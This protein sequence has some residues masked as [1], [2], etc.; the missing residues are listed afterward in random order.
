MW[1]VWGSRNDRKHGKSP[2]PL[3]PAI[4]WALDA[5]FHLMNVV[6]RGNQRC[7]TKLEG[8]WKKPPSGY[9]KINT[10]G[11]FEAE[12]MSGATG[13]VIRDGNGVFIKAMARKLPSIASALVAEAEAWRDGLR[14]LGQ[15]SYQQVVLESNSLELITLWRAWEKQQ[16]EITPI[17]KEI[18]TMVAG[19]SSFKTLHIRRTGNMVAH[20]VLTMPPVFRALFGKTT[21]QASLLSISNNK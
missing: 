2:I 15:S 16:S 19:I 10:D 17:L 13:V 7:R 11:G 5:C 12:S 14:L 1:S 21:R 4:D 3:K 9:V 8:K 20:F 18:Q 6:Q